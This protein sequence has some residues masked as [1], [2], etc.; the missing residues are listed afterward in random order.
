MRG[1]I[2]L[3][4]V[5]LLKVGRRFPLR[6]ENFCFGFSFSWRQNTEGR[7]EIRLNYWE[8]RPKLNGSYSGDN[9]KEELMARTP[10][11]PHFLW[12]IWVTCNMFHQHYKLHCSL[13]RLKLRYC[14]KKSSWA[15][16]FDCQINTISYPTVLVQ[17]H[18]AK[19]SHQHIYGLLIG[20]LWVLPV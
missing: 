10:R 1:L 18:C 9:P 4:S 20:M 12:T 2:G 13:S 19:S 3:A 6:R 17:P 16:S 8:T 11:R 15:S 14:S 5:A 7:V